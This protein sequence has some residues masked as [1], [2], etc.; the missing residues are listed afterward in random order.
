MNQQSQEKE[1]CNKKETKVNNI[2]KE[3]RLENRRKTLH[4]K[5]TDL[6]EESKNISLEIHNLQLKTESN[7][8]E[9]EVLENYGKFVENV[10]CGSPTYK[11]LEYM[12]KQKKTF[13]N[14]DALL[15]LAQDFQK[16]V[17]ER[18][19]KLNKLKEENEENKVT[20]ENLRIRLLEV[21]EQLNE[22][23][24]EFED[25]KKKLLLHYHLLL[26]EGTDTRTEGL[27]WIIKS[28]WNLG[29]NVILSYMP[30]YLDEKCIDFLFSIAHKDYE[31]H[32]MNE[33]LEL[34]KL[35]LKNTIAKIGLKA[36]VEKKG[37]L[38]HDPSQSKLEYV[39]NIFLIFY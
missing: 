22:I 30:N 34:T 13:E 35:S 21:K 20:K 31:L 26:S 39:K 9:I 14:Q 33:D 7:N 6:K 36:T 8:A 5:M 12:K 28:I 17:I 19:N 38:I 15:K 2:S 11:K 24:E 4:D 37:T 27:V 25:V 16:E 32:Q 1:N 29:E 18:Q 10:N 3:L 23:R